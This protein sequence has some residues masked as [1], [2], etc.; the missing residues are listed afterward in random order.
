METCLKTS[1]DIENEGVL[2]KMHSIFTY[3]ILFIN[4]FSKKKLDFLRFLVLLECKVLLT[5]FKIIFFQ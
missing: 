5:F 4:F 1:Y 3:K 2:Q